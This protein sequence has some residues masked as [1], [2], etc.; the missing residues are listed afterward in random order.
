MH[1]VY[2]FTAQ[3][4]RRNAGEAVPI[5]RAAWLSVSSPVPAVVVALPGVVSGRLAHRG[6][7]SCRP[8]FMGHGYAF[9]SVA[10][11]APATVCAVCARIIIGA[12]ASLLFGLYI[13]YNNT[14]VIFNKRQ[15]YFMCSFNKSK[16]HKKRG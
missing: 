3:E 9:R 10:R 16:K 8:V 6:A 13:I 15:R 7:S 12:C 4:N 14:A 1:T 5:W 2:I 11:A